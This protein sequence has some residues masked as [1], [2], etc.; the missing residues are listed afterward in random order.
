MPALCSPLLEPFTLSVPN[1]THAAGLDINV[2]ITSSV[3]LPLLQ[4]VT[5]QL[6]LKGPNGT[7]PVVV[8]ALQM[9]WRL[10]DTTGWGITI[11][12][13][14]LQLA[15]AG[16]TRLVMSAGRALHG[17]LSRSSA[18]KSLSYA[19]LLACCCCHSSPTCIRIYALP[20]RSQAGTHNITIATVPAG[21]VFANSNMPLRLAVIPAA[22]SALTSK[23]AISA[24]N[25]AASGALATALLALADVFG[26]ARPDAEGTQLLIRGVATGLTTLVAAK[27]TPQPMP[28]FFSYQHTFAAIQN[29]TFELRTGG[30]LTGSP[31]MFPAAGV[32]PGAVNLTGSLNAATLQPDNADVAPAASWLP[33]ANTGMLAAEAWHKVHVPVLRAGAGAWAGRFVADPGLSVRLR[34]TSI[35]PNGTVLVAAAREYPGTWSWS[36][37]D[38][39]VPLKLPAH[40][41]S[42]VEQRFAA[43]LSLA[44]PSG[45]AVS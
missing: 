19:Y 28:G 21:V 20:A 14:M 5:L 4:G 29:V 40:D 26:N 27:F 25:G 11:P 22:V 41:K 33:L 18:R 16:R 15:S 12:G 24:P 17:R 34:V 23:L 9:I 13:A 8:G 43:M 42:V 7:A 37:G 3:P 35:A 31:I 44:H 30:A 32:L 10:N 1:T 45:A 6:V 39:V 38:Y 2:T 36:G